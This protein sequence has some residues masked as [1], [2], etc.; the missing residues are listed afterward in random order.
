MAKP[1]LYLA[2]PLFS[3]AERNFNHE[4]KIA[5]TPYFDVYLSQEDGGLIVEMIK[6][7]TPVDIVYKDV[8]KMDIHAIEKADVFL[9]ILD[10]RAIDEGN[11]I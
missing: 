10:G 1:K 3:D 2:G 8:F 9:A 5:L 7:G 4:L 11:C 6:S